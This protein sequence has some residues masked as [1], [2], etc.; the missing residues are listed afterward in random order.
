M[1]ITHCPGATS[2][3]KDAEIENMKDIGDDVHFNVPLDALW[4]KFGIFDMMIG[5]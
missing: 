3:L 4:D 2:L 5:I 1:S